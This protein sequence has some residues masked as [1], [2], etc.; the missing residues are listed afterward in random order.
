VVKS[1][2]ASCRSTAGDLINNPTNASINNCIIDQAFDCFDSSKRLIYMAIRSTAPASSSSSSPS[3]ALSAA[4]DDDVATAAAAVDAT[5]NEMPPFADD[6]DVDAAAATT[7][8]F[9]R[10]AARSTKQRGQ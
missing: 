8:G 2:S 3:S 10:C 6:D 1:L 5:V 4:T 9:R 7:T